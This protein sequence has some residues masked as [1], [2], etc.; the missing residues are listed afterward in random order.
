VNAQPVEQPIVN[1]QPVEQP[2]V[3]AQPVEQNIVNSETNNQNAQIANNIE[4]FTENERKKFGEDLNTNF[5]KQF[6]VNGFAA[7]DSEISK[8]I[9]KVLSS[10]KSTD[11]SIITTE[12]F[13]AD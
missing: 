13:I 7:E 6:R 11:N 1:A 4:E 12:K 9:K 3:N 5:Q 8:K 2:I 10:S